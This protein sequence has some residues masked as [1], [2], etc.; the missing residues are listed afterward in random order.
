MRLLINNVTSNVVK[1]MRFSTT[2]LPKNESVLKQD[3]K[4]STGLHRINKNCKN[5]FDLFKDWYVAHQSPN[6]IASKALCFS[7]ANKKGE[8]SSRTLILRRLDEDGMV[9][10]TDNRSRK[11]RD[12]NEN[13]YAS[14]I[15]LWISMKDDLILSRQ[16]RIEGSVQKLSTDNMLE[17]YDAEPLFC[18]IRAHICH[19]G[20]TV[21]WNQMKYNHDSLLQKYEENQTGLPKP[22]HVVA[23]KLIP[24]KMEFYESLGQTIADRL[25]YVKN[26]ANWDII[27][28]AA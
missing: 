10:M 26:N 3:E 6:Q 15:F 14:M 25:L 18:K 7:T 16:A 2:I 9:I 28:L 11:A 24:T 20:T 12:L 27:R 8:I 22:N 13:P 5:P 23:Y 1:F 21:D 17:I 4:E 19:Q